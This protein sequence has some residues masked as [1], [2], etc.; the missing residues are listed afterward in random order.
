MCIRDRTR[1]NSRGKIRHLSPSSC[2]QPPTPVA[3]CCPHMRTYPAGGH[4]IV[5]GS[6][7]RGHQYSSHPVKTL[8]LFI[9]R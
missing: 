3:P 9:C 1:V 4:L 2:A 6:S 5:M 7:W 8:K